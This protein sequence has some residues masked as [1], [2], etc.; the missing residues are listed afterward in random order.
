MFTSS[1]LDDA[2]SR[3]QEAAGLCA[4][5]VTGSS[6]EQG[7][8]RS[9][10]TI[11]CRYGPGWEPYRKFWCRGAN[12][13][14]CKTLV[15]TT[16]SEQEV[17]RGRVSIR[18]HHNDR[19]FTVTMEKLRLDDADTYWCG[20]DKVEADLRAQVEVTIDRGKSMCLCGGLCRACSVLVPQVPVLGNCHSESGGLKAHGSQ[21]TPGR[22]G[23]R[24]LESAHIL[25]LSPRSSLLCCIHFWLPVLLKLPL[26]LCLL[27]AILWV[28]RPQRGPPD[29]EPATPCPSDQ[30][31]VFPEH[32]LQEDR[33]APLCAA[34]GCSLIR[35]PLQTSNMHEKGAFAHSPSAGPESAVSAAWPRRGDCPDLP[36]GGCVGSGSRKA[37]GRSHAGFNAPLSLLLFSAVLEPEHFRLSWALRVADPALRGLRSGA[38]AGLHNGEACWGPS[39]KL[40]RLGVGQSLVRAGR[41]RELRQE[42]EGTGQRLKCKFNVCV[43]TEPGRGCSRDRRAARAG[44][45]LGGLSACLEDGPGQGLWSH[46]LLPLCVQSGAQC[47]CWCLDGPNI[48]T[49]SWG[50]S[51]LQCRYQ[52]EYADDVKFWCK[53]S[54][55]ILRERIA[56]TSESEREGRSGRVS[57]RDHPAKLTFTVALE[58]L[59]EDDEKIYLCGVGTPLTVDP[60][61][62]IE[63]SVSPGESLPHPALCTCPEP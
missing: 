14:S 31:Q 25:G 1:P 2:A 8:E 5:G 59:T 55:W 39:C 56:E 4:V 34:D 21:R 26:L 44:E 52:E 49:G 57:I 50:V 16:G 62:Q 32:K 6:A 45:E 63:V 43:R 33:V 3:R 27:G 12:W 54:W 58:Q 11:Q 38:G 42:Q 46:Q 48:M 9:S 41:C 10:L 15:E 40:S 19:T 28:R 13:S 30:S 60:P 37:W 36:T 53:D 20:I 35:S 61:L 22:A 23:K 51:E 47:G 7:W 17:K 24:A 18:D 29:M